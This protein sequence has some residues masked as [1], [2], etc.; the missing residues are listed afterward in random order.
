MP[1][2]TAAPSGQSPTLT[3]KMGGCGGRYR[4]GE[5]RRC[6]QGASTGNLQLTAAMARSW[7]LTTGDV[8][9]SG[10]REPRKTQR[11]EERRHSGTEGYLSKTSTAGRFAQALQPGDKPGGDEGREGRGTRAKKLNSPFRPDGALPRNHHTCPQDN[12]GFDLSEGVKS[13]GKRKRENRP[14]KKKGD[15]L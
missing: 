8:F 5:A 9:T 14:K 1:R 6:V 13:G 4:I 15:D 12:L 2:G 3:K 10:Q 7:A 11:K